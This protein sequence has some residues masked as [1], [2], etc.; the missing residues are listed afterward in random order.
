M[1]IL[2]S[3]K[4]VS[5]HLSIT[6]VQKIHL[7]S[8]PTV[9]QDS[10][11]KSMYVGDNITLQCFY[12]HTTLL[13]WYMQPLGEKPKLIS[14]FYVYGKVMTF[15]DKFKND[16]RFTLDTKHSNGYHLTISDLKL[17][18]SATYYCAVSA[19]MV[20]TFAE[21][22][23]VSVKSSGFNIR[24]L[25]HQSASETIQPGDSPWRT[26]NCAVHNVKCDAE[27][28]VYWFKD[29][30]EAHPGLIYAHGGWNDQCERKDNTHSNTC[31]YNLPKKNLNASHAETNYCAVASC[32][33]ALFGNK[34]KLD[35]SRE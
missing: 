22:A 12:G 4:R 10:G 1:S 19:G 25:V 26:L 7:T 33:H 20:L 27:E 32:R 18:D 35:S 23:T 5:S 31:S 2:N 16:S 14:T 8:S 13:F 34:T 30:Q 3:V 21:G 15:H 24:A 17:S 6:S 28:N 29:S 11:F 9:N